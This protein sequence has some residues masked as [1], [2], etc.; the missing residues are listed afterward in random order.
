METTAAQ[1]ADGSSIAPAG[2]GQD[3]VACIA[4]CY[5]NDDITPAKALKRAAAAEASRPVRIAQFV[6]V[7]VSHKVSISSVVHR[8]SLETRIHHSKKRIKIATS[9]FG[10]WRTKITFNVIKSAKSAAK[11]GTTKRFASS[12]VLRHRGAK[13]NSIV[14]EASGFIF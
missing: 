8:I 12:K 4:G 2:N 6:P 14:T 9:G 5:R 13:R 3:V 10:K 1:A 11:R 7:A